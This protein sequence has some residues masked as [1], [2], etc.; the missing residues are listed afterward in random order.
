MG[1]WDDFLCAVFGIN[2]PE[3]PEY[4]DVLVCK[5][6]ELLPTDKCTHII[7]K[8]YEEGTEPTKY[9]DAGYWHPTTCKFPVPEISKFI[10]WSFTYRG[11]MNWK[12]PNFTFQL[13]DRLADHIAEHANAIRLFSFIAED[14]FDVAN[15][16]AP[17]PV[18]A[19]G[20][21]QLKKLNNGY[22][23]EMKRRFGS[24]HRRKVSTI[25]CL[26]S[27]WKGKRF[28]YN[29]FNGNNNVNKTCTSHKA[30]LTHGISKSY[31][32]HF[33][34]MFV[35][36]FDNPY[37]FYELANELNPS[38]FGRGVIFR[39][40]REMINFL[41]SLGVPRERICTGGF[42]SRLMYDIL[43]MGVWMS[44]HGLGSLKTIKQWHRSKERRDLYDAGMMYGCGDGGDENGEAE[45]LVELGGSKFKRPSPEQLYQILRYDLDKDYLTANPHQTGNGV[46]F[47]SASAYAFGWAGCYFPNLKD[48]IRIGTRGLTKAECNTLGVSYLKNKAPELKKILKAYQDASRTS[49]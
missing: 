16:I 33:I 38:T 4:I 21:Y 6:S 3:E 31:Q 24:F 9:C 42:N 26:F 49:V 44:Y 12:T 17:F 2:C 28:A 7:T 11:N 22:I 29:Y 10:G 19:N 13:W 27:G 30:L 34:R 1:F 39:W 45:G 20:K 8:K 48:A 14:T 5:A 35:R 36:N 23:A 25:V 41:L 46:D 18:T 47:F 40:N 15:S 32:K 43:K 37:M